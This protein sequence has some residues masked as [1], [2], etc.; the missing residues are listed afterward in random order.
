MMPKTRLGRRQMTHLRVYSGAE[1]PH[2]AQ[3]PKTVELGG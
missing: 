1:H 3:Q 2:F